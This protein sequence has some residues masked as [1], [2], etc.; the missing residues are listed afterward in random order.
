M[1]I[2]KRARTLVWSC[3]NGMIND[4]HH[5]T[6]GLHAR[7]EGRRSVGEEQLDCSLKFPELDCWENNL[8]CA[9]LSSRPIYSSLLGGI[10]A[11]FLRFKIQ[12]ES[13]REHIVIS[14]LSISAE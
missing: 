10:R 7:P 12:L 13:C 3:A 5:R 2:V 6:P 8:A 11:D 1:Y 14:T 9:K 4:G